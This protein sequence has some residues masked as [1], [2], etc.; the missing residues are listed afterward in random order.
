[1]SY[2]QRMGALVSIGHGQGPR[3]Q[4]TARLSIERDTW[5]MDSKKKIVL[6]LNA[7][8]APMRKQIAF[9]VYT[10]QKKK[11]EEK[12]TVELLFG[13]CVRFPHYIRMRLHSNGTDWERE[14]LVRKFHLHNTHTY[15]SGAHHLVVLKT[16]TE[17]ENE[18]NK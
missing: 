2:R 5:K 14:L 18:I 9:K 10:A 17:K 13:G 15:A 11:K 4:H 7:R 1:M 16:E 6:K 12:N 8:T 3:T